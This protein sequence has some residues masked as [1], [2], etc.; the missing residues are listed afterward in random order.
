MKNKETRISIV[1]QVEKELEADIVV[2]RKGVI[3]KARLHSSLYQ[4]DKGILLGQPAMTALKVTSRIFGFCGGSHQLAAARALETAWNIKLSPTAKLLRSIGQAS[5]ILQNATRWFY[6]TF[7]PDLTNSKFSIY[8]LH[9]DTTWRFTAF[10]GSS[11]K[12]GVIA[13]SYPIG[14]YTLFAGQWPQAD[15]VTPGGVNS[16][17]SLKKLTKAFALLDKFRSEWLE[18]IWLGGTLERY[19]EIGTWDDLL[20]WMEEKESHFNSDLGLF[21][22]SSLEFGLDQLGGGGHHF[23]AYGTFYDPASNLVISPENH[24]ESVQLPGGFFDGQQYHALHIKEIAKQL[25]QNIG[26]AISYNQS[27]VETGPLARVLLAANPAMKS[28]MGYDV[29]FADIYKRKGVNVFTRVLARMHE[30][31][32]MFQFLQHWLSN[33]KI[34]QD[35]LKMAF[36][37][38]PLATGFGMTEAPRG[39]LAHY[40]ELEENRIKDYQI[41]APTL[42]NISSGQTEGN[43]SPLASALVGTQVNDFENPIEVGLIVRSFDAGLTCKVNLLKN[44]SEK[45]I[46]MVQL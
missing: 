29:L 21:I 17:L 44:P 18:P 35:E 34:D 24:P 3:T 2:N 9:E 12:K 37:P 32:R 16:Q 8:P 19:L 31:T 20:A 13:S 26:G 14:L 38:K 40:V 11:F 23:I 36:E 45:K 10:K 4:G 30:A 41:L 46:G 22:R 6:T 7:A 42:I 15:F 1:G 5:E 27:A 25:H 43:A 33:L 28:K 39:A